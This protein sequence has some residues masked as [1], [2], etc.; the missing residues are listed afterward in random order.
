MIKVIGEE[1]MRDQ[2]RLDS[3]KEISLYVG[4]EIRTCY[5]WAKELGL[6]VHKVDSAAPRSRVFAYKDEIDD[7][8]RQKN[9]LSSG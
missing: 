2:K 3:W 6:P 9:K 7:W 4:R 5:R 1:H 8:F